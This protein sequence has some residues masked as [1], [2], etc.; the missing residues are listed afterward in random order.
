M[1]I[2]R[3]ISMLEFYY[4]TL[5]VANE[6]QINMFSP[7]SLKEMVFFLFLHTY[8]LKMLCLAHLYCITEK[9]YSLY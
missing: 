4:S 8:V 6:L 1:Q 3:S 5:C 2:K 9:H 7:N